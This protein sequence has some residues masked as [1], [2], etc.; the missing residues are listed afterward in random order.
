MQL[1][2]SKSHLNDTHVPHMQCTMVYGGDI[3]HIINATPHEVAIMDNC[4]LVVAR[5]PPS[6]RPIRITYRLDSIGT[7][8]VHRMRSNLYH[9]PLLSMVR[10]CAGPLPRQQP[11]TYYIVSAIVAQ[12]Y[13]ERTDFL[14]VGGV[15]RDRK[16]RTIGCTKFISR[17]RRADRQ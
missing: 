16:G 9:V 14:T 12:A 5:Y 6:R 11:E 2:V 8:T 3:L 7:I 10:R 15:V 1:Y 4:G 13:P 17:A